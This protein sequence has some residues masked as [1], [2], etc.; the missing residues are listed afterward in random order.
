MKQAITGSIKFLSAQEFSCRF[1]CDTDWIAAMGPR[2]VPVYE[3]GQTGSYAGFPATIR[4]HYRNGMWAISL[5]GGVSCI[6]GLEFKPDLFVVFNQH[7]YE[8]DDNGFWANE[9]GWVK[10][11]DAARYTS[12]DVRQPLLSGQKFISL[13]DAQK[14]TSPPHDT[15]SLQYVPV[16]EVDNLESEI[17]FAIGALSRDELLDNVSAVN[18]DFHEKWT[19]NDELRQSLIDYANEN[20]GIVLS[21][22]DGDKSFGFVLISHETID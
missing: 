12:I 16:A 9:D 15:D 5:P 14:L 11:E 19:T 18:I 6:S 22:C 17:S 10:L 3:I 7:E 2:S 20:R 13:E 8:I 4:E 21:T 1:P